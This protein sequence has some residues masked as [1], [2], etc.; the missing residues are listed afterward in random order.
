[1]KQ[2]FEIRRILAVKVAVF[3]ILLSIAQLA[4]A[5]AFDYEKEKATDFYKFD[6]RGWLLNAK[7]TF[8][9]AILYLD[10]QG[11]TKLCYNDGNIVDFTPKIFRDVLNA[12]HKS[13]KI[14]Y[15]EYAY[16]P[17][18]IDWCDDTYTVDIWFKEI[19]TWDVADSVYNCNIL[20]TQV[21]QVI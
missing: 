15:Y 21:S 19:M 7:K 6:E 11:E 12:D 18:T 17:N 10:L 4:S 13:I 20:L 9:N 3:A 2:Q 5:Q 8:H 1:M 16:D 14:N